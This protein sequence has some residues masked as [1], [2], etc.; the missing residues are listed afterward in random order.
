MIHCLQYLRDGKVG[1]EIRWGRDVSL[2]A[3]GSVFSTIVVI[4]VEL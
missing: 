1:E 2:R 3:Y 4:L